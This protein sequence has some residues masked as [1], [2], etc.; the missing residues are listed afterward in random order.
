MKT[1]SGKT[2]ITLDAV[3]GDTIQDVKRKITDEI[4]IP[5]SQQ[6]LVFHDR[7]LEDERTLQ[8]YHITRDSTIELV[9][10]RNNGN[11]MFIYVRMQ[12][13]IRW[14][15]NVSP[16]DTTK[17]VKRKIKDQ[18]GIPINQLLI[19]FGD[20]ELEGDHTLRDYGVEHGCTLSM[21]DNPET[22]KKCIVS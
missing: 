22:H 1:Q 20:Y 5:A 10:T 9:I 19:T 3:S 18:V 11:E 2:K 12:N 16:E 21:V 8:S 17:N 15:V 7:E 14:R 4:G 13:G 6:Q